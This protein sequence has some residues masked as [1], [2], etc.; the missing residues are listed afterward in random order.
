MSDLSQ[1]EVTSR[2]RKHRQLLKK[3]LRPHGLT[4]A[5]SFTFPRVCPWTVLGAERFNDWPRVESNWCKVALSAPLED[6]AFAADRSTVLPVHGLAVKRFRCNRQEAKEQRGERQEAR[7]ADG[8]LRNVADVCRGQSGLEWRPLAGHAVAFSS[9][10]KSIR[11]R[12][13]ESRACVKK[14]RGRHLDCMA[15][16]SRTT[17]TNQDF[18]ATG[19]EKGI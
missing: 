19:T 1:R 9:V 11:S 10:W 4:P 8:F 17:N 15:T 13:K 7:V 5:Y 2:A 18:A 14:Y 16:G 3:I 12:G 6:Q